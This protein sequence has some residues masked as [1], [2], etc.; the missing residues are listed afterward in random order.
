MI[1][2]K[3]HSLAHMRKGAGKATAKN[4]ADD[5]EPNGDAEHQAACDARLVGR[6]PKLK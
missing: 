5:A 2:R 3:G 4:I 1:Q 6:L